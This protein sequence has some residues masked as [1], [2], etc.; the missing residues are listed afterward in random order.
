MSQSTAAWDSV[1]HKIYQSFCQNIVCHDPEVPF[2]CL[3][4]MLVLSCLLLLRPGKGA[5]AALSSRLLRLLSLTCGGL[6]KDAQGLAYYT[7]LW[8]CLPE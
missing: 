5:R 4:L 1:E 6:W 7:G 8:G 2:C 3:L